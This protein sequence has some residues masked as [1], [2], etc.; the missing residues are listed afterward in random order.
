MIIKLNERYEGKYELKADGGISYTIPNLPGTISISKE[1]V[2][3]IVKSV[4]T[5]IK[6]AL[7]DTEIQEE[8]GFTVEQLNKVL[9]SRPYKIEAYLGTYLDLDEVIDILLNHD[10]SEAEDDFSMI[11]SVIKRHSL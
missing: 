10:G 1:T 7:E 3:Y 6:E 8:F 2:D 5:R 9:Q 4:D 11:A